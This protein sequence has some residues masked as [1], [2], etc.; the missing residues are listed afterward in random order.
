MDSLNYNNLQA[1]TKIKKKGPN[2]AL[3][4]DLA[5]P[6]E[7]LSLKNTSYFNVLGKTCDLESSYTFTLLSFFILFSYK[8]IPC[9]DV[10][11]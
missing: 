11:A 5:T 6:I 4:F 2:Q 1:Q 7:S 9:I 3:K 10:L 8:V